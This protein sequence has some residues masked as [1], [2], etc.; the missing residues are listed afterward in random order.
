M[1][2]ETIHKASVHQ[3]SILYVYSL[4]LPAV[5]FVSL[6]V[7]EQIL[8]LIRTSARHEMMQP[9]DETMNIRESIHPGTEISSSSSPDSDTKDRTLGPSPSHLVRREEGSTENASS[10]HSETSAIEF[11]QEPYNTFQH[12]EVKLMLDLFPGYRVEDVKVERMQ[13]G[14]HNRIIGVT[15]CKSPPKHP[16]YSLQRIRNTIQPCLTGRRNRETQPTP[17]K[18]ILRIPRSPTQDVHHQ[19]TTLA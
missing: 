10:V 11:E 18:F 1:I 15:L 4:P 9:T 16:W 17:K 13:G 8:N 7:L 6:E 5:P 19:L 3:Q 12:K 2:S 14:K